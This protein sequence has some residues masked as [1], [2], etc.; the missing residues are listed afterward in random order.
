MKILIKN[1]NI[2]NPGGELGKRDILIENGVIADIAHDLSADAEIIDAPGLDAF[3]GFF[4]MHVHFREPGFEYKEDIASGALAAIHGGF[5]GV[6][7]MPNT[8]PAADSP[9]VIEYIINKGK[10]AGYAKVYP[11]GC[12]TKGSAGAELSEMGALK[13]AGAVALSDDGKPVVSANTMRLALQYASHFDLPLI[14]HCEVPELSAG[15]LMNEGFVSSLVGLKGIPYT[16]ETIMAVRDILLAESLNTRV[17][18][19]HV[20][21]AA[22]VNAIRDA[23]ARG[24]KVT[25]ETAPHYFSATDELCRDYD[26]NA[27]VNPPL[28]TAPDVEAIKAGLADGTIDA[29]ATDHAPHHIDEKRCEFANALS[30]L[31]GLELAFS[32]CA[33]HL[34]GVVSKQRLA[35]LLCAAPRKIIGIEGGTLE[36]GQK[37]DIALVNFSADVI[38]D[39]T[40]LYSKAGNTPF[41]NMPLKGRV[42]HTFVDGRQVIK[43]GVKVG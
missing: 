7:C 15:G 18:I 43:D 35:Q 24:V 32:L 37:A 20:S 38:Y 42:A 26:T 21:A 34:S 31:I 41:L 14:A 13:E 36:K 9:A 4:D 16:A 8:Q 11:I 39:E 10:K 29:I 23:K 27:K 28:R 40:G 6:A 5:T 1:A 25:C 17:H 19:A 3:P 12:I 22:T 33:T 2:V 30:G